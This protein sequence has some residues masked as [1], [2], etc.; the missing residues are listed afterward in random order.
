MPPAEIYIELV[1]NFPEDPKVRSLLRYGADARGLRDLYV[2]MALYAKRNLSDGFVPE[3]E[4]G[5]LVYPD[6]WEN[7]QRDAE[8]LIL[9]RLI[10]RVENG[11]VVLAYG[12]RNRTKAEVLQRTAEKSV[13]GVLGNHRRWH[14]NGVVKEGCRFCRSDTDRTTDGTSE[15]DSESPRS[16]ASAAATANAAVGARSEGPQSAIHASVHEQADIGQ[17]DDLLKLDISDTD[18][19]TD[20]GPNRERSSETETE[21]ETE[22]QKNPP[23]PQGGKRRKR[24][25]GAEDYDSDPDF[26]RFWNAYPEKGGKFDA[27]KAW[28]SAVA[29]GDNPELI[30]RAAAWYRDDPKRNPDATKWAQGWLNSRRYKEQQPARRPTSDEFWKN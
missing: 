9:A 11:Y 24:R 8:R 10:D 7:G 23:T 29:R 15:S 20:Q 16:G 17:A 21:T 27:F 4:I 1:V 2:Q 6:T 30:I 14:Q 19:T 3:E 13:G 25:V 26:V 22:E 28:Q 18:R 12:K 5:I